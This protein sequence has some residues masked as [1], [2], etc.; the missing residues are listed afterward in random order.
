M[1]DCPQ[2]NHNSLK[3]YNSSIVYAFNWYNFNWDSEEYRNKAVELAKASKEYSV[4]ADS[5]RD[6]DYSYVR[7]CAVYLHLIANGQILAKKH[8]DDLHTKLEENLDKVKNA[9]VRKTQVAPEVSKNTRE[10]ASKKANEMAIRE[11]CGQIDDALDEFFN[12]KKVTNLSPVAVICSNATIREK[13]FDFVNSIKDEFELA[14]GGT[15][16]EMRSAYSHYTVSE[17]KKL[18]AMLEDFIAS[19]ARL[20]KAK[21]PTKKRIQTPQQITKKI[22]TA[23]YMQ[24]NSVRGLQPFKFVGSKTMYVY[25]TESRRLVRYVA[26]NAM[27]LSANG[28]SVVNYDPEKSSSKTVR[29]PQKFFNGK[30]GL[31]KKTEIKEMWESIKGESKT[32][33]SRLNNSFIILAC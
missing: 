29:N 17:L 3:E 23:L 19:C 33:P 21:T 14:V 32:I 16:K 1:A 15:D 24:D 8:L 30:S 25:N 22:N 4:Y 9:V 11:A 31:L 5:L 7:A 26:Q 20:K 18:I 28:M 10:E 13:V 2:L 27:S 12:T 6:G